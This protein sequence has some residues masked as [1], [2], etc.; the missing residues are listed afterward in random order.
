[1]KKLLI[2]LFSLFL[3]NSSSVFADDISDFEIEGISIGDSLL[4]YMTEDEILKEIERTKDIYYYL[5]E[6]Y[7]YSEVY[8]YEDFPTYK[9]GLSFLVKN[10]HTSQYINN[11]ND[12]F[13]IVSIRGMIDYI[14]DF[15][16]CIAK[17][18]EI[19]EELSMVFPN[20]EKTLINFAHPADP[21]GNSVIDGAYFYFDLGGKSEVS[22]VNFEETFRIK[23][24]WSEGLD[25]AID[26]EEIVKWLEDW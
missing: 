5:N 20:A 4:D 18:D 1:M 6:P 11:I 16:G 9:D 10:N 8:L 14:E 13:T 23:K 7:K 21:S 25:V 17:K 2:L 26:T 22:C 19:V 24:T 3:L 12:K 15:D